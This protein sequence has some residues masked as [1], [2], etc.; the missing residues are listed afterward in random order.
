MNQPYRSRADTTNLINILTSKLSKQHRQL[1]WS[2]QPWY[3]CV[4]LSSVLLPSRGDYVDLLEE[5][6]VEKFCKTPP[7]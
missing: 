1:L 5:R 6:K 7:Q 4:T 3:S 2:L